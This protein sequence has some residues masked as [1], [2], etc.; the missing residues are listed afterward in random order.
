M[1]H[2]SWNLSAL[3]GLGA[4]ALCTHGLVGAQE[5]DG[6]LKTRAIGV[7]P[8]IR[9]AA[10]QERRSQVAAEPRRM[11]LV[12]GNADYRNV[13]KLVNPRNDASSLCEALRALSFEVQCEF[14]VANR[15]AFREAVRKF[16]EKLTPT[17]AAFFYF[18]GHGVQI[19]GENY[20]LP[21]GI[22]ARS[23]ADIEDEAVNLG[24]LLRS[25]EEARSSPNIVVL[26]AC[27]DNPFPTLRSGT[28]A[29][30][31]ARVDP[32]VGTMLVYATA[33]NG[34]ALDGTERNGVFTKHLLQSLPVPGQGLD[35]LFQTVARAVEEESRS[36][37]RVQVP[38]RSSSFSGDFCLAGCD[39]PEVAAQLER[40]KQ[41]R[42][43]AEKRIAHL[44]QENAR[45]QKVASSR[46]EHV[47]E[48][49]R[50]IETFKSQAS[51]SATD[52]NAEATA[53]LATLEAALG[54]ALAEQADAEQRRAEIKA[55]E[56]EIAQLRFQINDLSSKAK[57]LE[58]YRRQVQILE[59]QSA[60]ADVR[61][62][63]ITEENDRLRRHAMERTANVEA[64]ERQIKELNS[65]VRQHGDA[66]NAKEGELAR[67]RR[68][69]EQAHADKAAEEKLRVQI[70]T[71]ESEIARLQ[72]Q[73][74]QM[75]QKGQDL[76]AQRRELDR[77]L[78]ERA[79][80]PSPTTTRSVVIPS[81]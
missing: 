28:I 7:P 68:A 77:Q 79:A 63:A 31:L 46:N 8:A 69:L 75:Q 67:L 25:L 74:R 22:D 35:V 66:G 13:A 9:A 47:V 72:D 24:Y 14:D 70:A 17:T 73:M 80:V 52:R 23:T 54:R 45:L 1:A 40:I 62:R 39:R 60:D 48:L 20:L 30:G 10:A 51:R 27:R 26:D 44:T 59:K 5:P 2:L 65:T 6:D 56:S 33:P 50:R 3:I 43:E 81:F 32:P 38:Y 41:E 55:R 49:E 21:I 42:E 18:A 53:Q 57:Q 34:V 58:D 16:T 61:L 71:R 4:I 76:E 78:R 37:G 19:A 36:L 64:L 11:A 15:R 12:I 29:R